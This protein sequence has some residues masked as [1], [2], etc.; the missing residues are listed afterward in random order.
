MIHRTD[1]E[2]SILGHPERKFFREMMEKQSSKAYRGDNRWK[3]DP[4]PERTGTES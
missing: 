4:A 2:S 3:A 1:L